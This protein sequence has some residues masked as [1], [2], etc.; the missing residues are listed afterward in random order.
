MSAGKEMS[1]EVPSSDSSFCA[2]HPASA[3][4]EQTL[5]VGCRQGCCDKKPNPRVH[6]CSAVRSLLVVASCPVPVCV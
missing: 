2:C 1:Q 5:S 4:H 3:N 6:S